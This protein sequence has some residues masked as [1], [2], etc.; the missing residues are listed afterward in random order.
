MVFFLV[1]EMVRADKVDS[2]SV[3]SDATLMWFGTSC[4]TLLALSL[5]NAHFSRTGSQTSICHSFSGQKWYKQHLQVFA[6]GQKY[7]P[8]IDQQFSIC[9]EKKNSEWQGDRCQLVCGFNILRFGFL[10]SFLFFLCVFGPLYQNSCI[11]THKQ[12]TICK[13]TNNNNNKKKHLGYLFLDTNSHL[14]FSKL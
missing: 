10:F 6:W 14:L 12:Y 11:L 13:Q 4:R 7:C 1:S 9:S 3:A 2:L 8:V 5:A